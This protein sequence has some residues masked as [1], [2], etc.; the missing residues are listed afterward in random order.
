M[1]S[2]ARLA[3]RMLPCWRPAALGILLSLAALLANLGLL[4][5]SGWFIASM[6]IAGSTGAFMAYTLPAAGVRALALA[7]AAG[8]YAE[9]LVNHDT[10]FRILAELRVWFFRRIEPLAPARLVLYRGGDLLSRIRAD[11][12]TLD[13]FYVRGLV[14]SVVAVLA[15]SLIAPFLAR[16]DARLA[17]IGMSALAAAGGI[18]PLLL[19]RLAERPGRE[20]VGCAADLRALLVEQVQGMGE[21]IA[22]GAVEAH[23]A[24]IL[25]ADRAL[26]RRQRSLSSLQG[27]GEAGFIAAG[28]LAVWAAALLL[29]PAVAAGALPPACLAMLTV[30]ILASFESVLPLPAAIQRAG[31]MAA[32]ARR[33][34][35]IIDRRPAVAEPADPPAILPGRFSAVP[36]GLSIRGLRFRYSPDRPWVIDGLSL[37]IPA[38]GRLAVVG[39]TGAGKS[40][41]VNVLLRFWDYEG[42]SIRIVEPPPP[43]RGRA[44]GAQA[45]QWELRALGGEDARRLFS[46]VPQ[47]P[48]LFHATIRENLQIAAPGLDEEALR[49]ALAAAQL[50]G[51]VAALPD[52]LETIVGE[53]GKEISVGER[54]RIAVARAL[55]KEAPI[56]LF[57]EPTE[58]LDEAT[59]DALLQSIDRR[60]QGRT[61]IVISHRP[62]DL[63]IA[64]RVV[65]LPAPAGPP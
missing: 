28:S 55:L 13:D 50:T 23:T 34:F 16:F 21:L 33:L 42:G 22:L 24:R 54:Q 49:A 39:P 41:L 15:L 18:L 38:G 5:L 48:Y 3:E 31:E 37:D 32:A 47:L 61:L 62:R 14:P 27:A 65:A 20:R 40:S 59:A 12:D 44:T 26:D 56:Y 1:K 25:A 52:G 51:F 45:A 35:E 4:A 36:L 7:R 9:R 63:R 8:R 11:I 53:S 29:A 43:A 17:W 10:T 64:D 46:V 58:G 60:L 30:F 2:L 57:D 19:R 6:A